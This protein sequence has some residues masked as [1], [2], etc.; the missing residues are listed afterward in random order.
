MLHRSLCQQVVIE[1]YYAVAEGEA[2]RL[3]RFA[4]F[5]HDWLCAM[6]DG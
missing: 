1:L 6:E 5:A 3:Y 2:F 4:Y